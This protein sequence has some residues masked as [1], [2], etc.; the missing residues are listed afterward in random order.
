MLDIVPD[1]INELEDNESEAAPD[2]LHH[3]SEVIYEIIAVYYS[4]DLPS[5]IK[6]HNIADCF[7]KKE[8]VVTL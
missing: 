2:I 5:Y 6:K 8:Q 4:G 1:L 3:S 7:S